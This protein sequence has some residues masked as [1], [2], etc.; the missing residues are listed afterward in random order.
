MRELSSRRGEWFSSPA[1]R[2]LLAV[3]LA[4]SLVLGGSFLAVG[5]L[6]SSPA[7]S[8]EH[9]DRT[10]TDGQTKTEVV[11]QAK[12]IVAIARFQQPTAGYL[13]L[14][15]KNRDDP[16][17]Q[18]AVYMNFTLPADA[19]ADEYFQTIAAAMAGRGWIE[20]L[21]PNQHLYGKTL[22][23]DG[24]TAILYRDSDYSNRGIA[25]L[26]GQCRNMNNHRGDTTAWVDIT[27]Q[28]Q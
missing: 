23:K 13:L 24:V 22:S 1:A 15:C 20:G 2:I 26:Y 18:G 6:H 4:M 27:D 17:Y 8:L 12:H 28:L 3:A 5:R 25:R 21:P 19:R 10:A 9:P 7:D 16:P 14:S 11:E